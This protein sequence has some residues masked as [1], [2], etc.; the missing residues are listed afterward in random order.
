MRLKLKA[1]AQITL[2][3]LLVCFAQT[4]GLADD[5]KDPSPTITV[6]G[7]AE[8]RVAPDEAV[9]TFSIESRETELNQTVKDNDAKI[10]AVT[11]FLKSSK[12]APKNI[13]TQVISIRPIFEGPKAYSNFKQSY[14]IPQ[15]NAAPIARP[16]TRDEK[17]K[18]PLKPIG[19]TA[20]RQLPVTITDLNSFE[21]VYRGLIERGVNSVSGIE[22]RTTE[23]RK[24]RDEAR[25]KAVRAAKEKATAMAGELGATL[26]SVQTISEEGSPRHSSFQNSLTPAFASAP[27]SIATGVI[28]INASVRVVF[29]LGNYK[30]DTAK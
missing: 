6:S 14:A 16:V 29:L 17:K 27:T 20:S 11:D 26:A 4:A 1:P 7:S 10:K 25:L 28:E 22:F 21:N 9:L 23:L 15:S 18:S 30:L 24:H 2:T 3:I 19:Y 13:R 8:I 5:S 12:V